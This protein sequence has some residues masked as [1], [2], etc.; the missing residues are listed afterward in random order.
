MAFIKHGEVIRVSELGALVA[1]ATSVSIRANVLTPETLAGLRQWGRDVRA[2][3]SQVSLTVAE[4]A[5]LPAIARYLVSQ[6]VEVYALAPQH[7][8]LEDLF[9]QVVGTDG[10][11]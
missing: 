8:S 7:L 5:A 9:I 3:G 10:G 2:D 4:D 1:G 6:N 11:L